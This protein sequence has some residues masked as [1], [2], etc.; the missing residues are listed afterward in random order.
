MRSRRKRSMQLF[1]VSLLLIAMFALLRGPQRLTGLV[2]YGT[3]DE[4]QQQVESF[5]AA[6]PPLR[7][8][9]EGANMCLLIDLGYDS[10][11]AY[12]IQKSGNQ[13][14]V[15]PIPSMDCGGQRDFVMKFVNPACG[16]F[17]VGGHGEQFW[18]LASRMWPQGGSPTCNAEFQQKY[19]TALYY[20]G[21]PADL[22]SALSC[23]SKDQLTPA[24][25]TLAASAAQSGIDKN[26][27]GPKSAV[28]ESP[29]SNMKAILA[30]G[31]GVLIVIALVMGALLLMRK[32]QGAHEIKKEDVSAQTLREYIKS[33]HAAGFSEG[34]IASEL[35]QK[36]WPEDMIDANLQEDIL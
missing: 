31:L 18:Y 6:F 11:Y 21:E 24:Q 9:G 10:F 2:T 17:L 19:C 12:A 23:C 20:C 32:E 14:T 1:A 4:V 34:E 15:T 30:W 13:V 5:V 27:R 26:A 36:G 33:T 35:R 25:Q 29:L 8:S 28:L 3:Q 16:E 7:F 22:S